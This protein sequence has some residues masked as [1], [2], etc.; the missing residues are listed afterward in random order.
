MECLMAIWISTTVN[1]SFRF[2]D[3]SFIQA[4]VYMQRYA[5]IR[6]ITM[7]ACLTL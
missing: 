1:W 5:T 2:F 7:E 4:F 3:Y 6:D